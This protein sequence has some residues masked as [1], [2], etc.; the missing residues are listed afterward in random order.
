[1]NS[2]LL[3]L[4]SIADVVP[5]KECS[6]K[7]VEKCLDLVFEQTNDMFF[8]SDNNYYS[9]NKE[10]IV[11]SLTKSFGYVALKCNENKCNKCLISKWCSHYRGISQREEAQRHDMTFADFF[12][13]AGG[14]SLGFKQAGFKLSLAND[15][16]SCCIDTYAFNTPDVPSKHIIC[17]DINDVLSEITKL[18]RYKKTDVV[19]GGPP[20][21]GF[22][23]ANRQRL[24]DDPRNRLYKS[25]IQAVDLL[26][27]KFVVMENVRGILEYKNDIYK[28]YENIGYHVKAKVLNA[29]DFGV[30]QNR[31]RTIFLA[32]RIGVE[33]D[34]IFREIRSVCN[35][36]N[37]TNLYDAII[38]LPTLRARTEK[39]NYTDD[40][41]SGRTINFV[42]PKNTT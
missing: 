39:N 41:I 27:P 34:E 11:D 12:C 20:C 24:I 25:F 32:N 16:Q 35:D 40:D 28:D 36:I 6:K 5:Y 8:Q 22:S 33:N 7:R 31:Y 37:K 3:D 15:I 13:G 17:G 30:P 2:R 1:M 9:M 26:R 42:S 19:I 29:Y 21:Q 38:D 14:L 23:M 4:Y 18:K 10:D